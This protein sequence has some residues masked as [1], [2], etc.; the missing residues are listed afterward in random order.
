MSMT[1][2]GTTTM[3]SVWTGKKSKSG[4]SFGVPLT[5][6][7]DMGVQAILPVDKVAMKLSHPVAKD[8]QIYD[9]E[10]G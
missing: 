5:A 6:Q 1:L 7:L 4:T 3:P 2:A 8:P 9:F 10:I